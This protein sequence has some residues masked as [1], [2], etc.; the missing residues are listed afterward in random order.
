MAVVLASQFLNSEKMFPVLSGLPA[1]NPG[2]Q[3]DH[4]EQQGL[5]PHDSNARVGMLPLDRFAE[6]GKPLGN[7]VCEAWHE[8]KSGVVPGS[9]LDDVASRFIRQLGNDNCLDP[10][11]NAFYVCLPACLPPTDSFTSVT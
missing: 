2:I 1:S 8:E 7:L 4:S 10:N 11:K 5:V 3:V 6:R 9:S